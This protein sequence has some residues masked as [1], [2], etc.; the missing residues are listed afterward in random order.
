MKYY[1]TN[2]WFSRNSNMPKPV[3]D[4]IMAEFNK[5]QEMNPY[6]ADYSILIQYL[7]YVVNLPWDISTKETLDLKN[8]KSVNIYEVQ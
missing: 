1:I 4:S 3:Y 8:A 7:S 5:L 2:N 6:I